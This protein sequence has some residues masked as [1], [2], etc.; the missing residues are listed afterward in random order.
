MYKEKPIKE[1]IKMNA[2]T[3]ILHLQKHEHLSIF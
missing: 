3:Y 2:Q 1:K